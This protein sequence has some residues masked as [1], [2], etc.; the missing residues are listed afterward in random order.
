MATAA[1]SAG[2][3][4]R[5]GLTML[6]GGEPLTRELADRLLAGGG[7]LWNMYG[8]T[9]TT[10]WS[11]CAR[12]EPGA[13]PIT[14]G[15]PI[16]NTQCYVLDEHDRTVP[17]GTGG[18]LHIAGDGVALGYVGRPELTAER[19]VPNPFGP[20]RMYRTGRR[21]AGHAA[22]RDRRAR[23]AR[24]SGQTARL[25]HRT[26]RD[27]GRRAGEDRRRRGRRRPARGCA[28]RSAARLLLR[29][30]AGPGARR[31]ERCARSPP[32]ICPITCSR[33]PGCGSSA[34]RCRSPER[35]IAPRC[36][37]PTPPHRRLRSAHRA[38]RPRSRSRASGPRCCASSGSGCD[39]DFFALGGDSIHLFQIT[40]RANQSGLRLAAK[41]L[42]T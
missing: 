33:R 20:G 32:R 11:T 15:T 2:F 6:C 42:L 21:R 18:Q 23:A 1:S 41:E 40:A 35:S 14:V 8:P 29:R 3:A 34:C 31:G 37:R 36:R 30:A 12:V 17:V 4:S 39:D 7:T 28:G 19:F 13:E 22:R 26:R 25:P 27:R 16:D 5:P 38:R 9:E 24:S 10:I